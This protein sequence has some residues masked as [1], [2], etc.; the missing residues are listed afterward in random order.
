MPTKPVIRCRPR[1][2][3]LKL[4]PRGHKQGTLLSMRG[5]FFSV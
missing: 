5:L 4:P 1:A 3:W 2:R